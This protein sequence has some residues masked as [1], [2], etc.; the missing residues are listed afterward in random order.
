MKHLLFCFLIFIFAAEGVYGD[1]N[2]P[3]DAELLVR[4]KWNSVIKVL[5][6]EQ[7]D[8]KAKAEEIS[9]IA[10]PI[11]DFPLIAKLSLGRKHW[12]K[13]TEPQRE[14]FTKLFVEHIK[15]S[16]SEKIAMYTD[17]EVVFKESVQKKKN[18]VEIPVE[19]ISKEKKFAIVHKLRKIDKHW[20]IYDVEI[21]GV[22]L[23][24]TYRSQF[25][26]ILSRGTVEDLFLQLENT[27]TE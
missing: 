22:S 5:K 23:L 19:M 26:D 2:D 1:T 11:F 16:Y 24:L 3:K 18:T 15:S 7:M 21:E 4:S 6:N 8:E 10:S 9:K 14:K 12:P 13:L 25:D 27:E 20:K 17:E